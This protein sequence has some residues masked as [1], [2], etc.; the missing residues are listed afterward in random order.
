M[1]E[2][3]SID[4]SHAKLATDVAAFALGHNLEAIS[5]AARGCKKASSVRQLAM[6]LTY[7]TFEMSLARCAVAFGRD[8]ST[9]AHACQL[10]E[11]RRDEEAFDDWI[12]GLEAG[13]NILHSFA[14]NRAKARS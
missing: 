3:Q 11:E 9:V 7:T 12:D 4:R 10:I 6:Y 2:Q 1:T 14:P 13:L 8:R 5:G